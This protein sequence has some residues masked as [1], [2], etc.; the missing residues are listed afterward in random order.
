VPS[1]REVLTLPYAISPDGRIA[2]IEGISGLYEILHEL[3]RVFGEVV[4]CEVAH[5]AVTKAAPAGNVTRK[6]EQGKGSE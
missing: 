1:F 3:G 2:D 5:S 6:C 4:L